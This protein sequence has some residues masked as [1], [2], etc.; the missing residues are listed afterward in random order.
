IKQSQQDLPLSFSPNSVES[1]YQK[2]GESHVHI[3]K[4]EYVP[5]FSAQDAVRTGTTTAS[6]RNKETRTNT[7]TSS[8]DG[9]LSQNLIISESSTFEELT[10]IIS[11]NSSTTKRKEIKTEMPTVNALTKRFEASSQQEKIL[12][13]QPRNIS[14]N[15][16]NV[17]E[18]AKSRSRIVVIDKSDK[19]LKSMYNNAAVVHSPGGI[20]TTTIVDIE[21]A[22]YGRRTDEYKIK[23]EYTT[24]NCYRSESPWYNKE[25]Q[26]VFQK[27][28]QKSNDAQYRDRKKYH[29]NIYDERTDAVFQRSYSAAENRNDFES[30]V[31]TS[32][33]DV[34][35]NVIERWETKVGG[36]RAQVT[37][38]PLRSVSRVDMNDNVSQ[39]AQE[40]IVV[41]QKSESQP[42]ERRV[43]I[44]PLPLPIE[45][46][47]EA[48]IETIEV[49]TSATSEIVTD[50][51]TETVVSP[52][53]VPTPSPTID[54]VDNNLETEHLST[55]EQTIT[56]SS[57]ITTNTLKQEKSYDSLIH[58]APTDV[59]P[60]NDY[61]IEKNTLDF[62]TQKTIE[63]LNTNTESISNEK[64]EQNLL[65]ILD[66][67]YHSKTYEEW[68]STRKSRNRSQSPERPFTSYSSYS[69]RS[70]SIDRKYEK[71]LSGNQFSRTYSE[72]RGFASGA[73]TSGFGGGLVSGIS[74]AGAICTTQIR[75]ARER[76]KREIGLLNDRL[77]DYIEKVRFLEAQNQCLSHDIDIL[78]RGF[79]GGGHVS[80]LFDTEIAQAKRILEQTIAGRATFDRDINALSADIEAI[81][82][83]W[84]ETVTAVKAHR[85]DHDVDLDRLAKIEAEISLFKRK[86]RIVE[87]DVIRIRR[88]NDG[89]YNEIARIKQ[90]T[91]NEVALRNERSLNVQD[92]L[93]RIKLLQTENNSRIE[94]ELVFIR[95]DTTAE[96][97]DYFRHELQAAIRDIRADYE[98]SESTRVNPDLYKEELSS[99]RTTVTNVKSR[100]AEVEGRVSIP[101][102]GKKSIII[103][104]FFLEKLI[105]DLKNNEESK[106]YEISLSEKDAQ[107][108]RLREQCT[109]L[110]IQMEKLCDNEISLRAEIER[111]RILLNGANVT[112]YLPNTH[113]SASTIQVGGNIG[114]TR[115]ISE[116]TRTHS[117]SNTS[118]S[119][120]PAHR[121][122][123]TVGGNIGGVSVGGTVG[124]N[125][126][127]AGSALSHTGS[128]ASL[129]SDKRPDRV[130]DEKGNDESGRSYHRWYLGTISINQ[131]TPSY[132][133]LKNICKIRRVDVGGF[134]VEQTRNGQLLGS[135]QINVPLILDPQ[136]VVRF[137][138]RH[139][140][141]LGQF[142]MDVDAFDNSIEARTSMFNYTEPDVE[143]AWFVY[144]D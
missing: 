106:L 14:N 12:P 60:F 4:L 112:T 86:I 65:N 123:Y 107:I 52:P 35:K 141:Y 95:R 31:D 127:A 70:K 85:E 113:P 89:I 78:R 109:E 33:I 80:G 6:N 61:D 77:A 53:I 105:E 99:I 44:S 110:S 90:L 124:V 30:P 19:T 23:E 45:K 48:K 29:Q 13:L 17:N 76:E 87:E 104:N 58:E 108:A 84:I 43:V 74:S 67:E 114:T 128:V 69:D 10:T 42:I 71:S 54:I 68:S 37:E 73:Y 11:S 41:I 137:N 94:Q 132:I 25:D 140:K 119:G 7:P 62:G 135:A 88:E 126:G 122:G 47:E 22:R 56:E 93:Q 129:I 100:L 3:R 125:R 63:N 81:R 8:L 36:N 28:H 117:S 49:K 46:K 1:G 15:S 139:G 133:E 21:P 55:I 97:R 26:Q 98:V 91:N 120:I 134:R 51:S 66:R 2:S 111:Y 143:R 72:G 27:Q 38:L 102:E 34:V 32:S 24:V 130:H 138:N 64:T 79:S 9:R 96:N 101:F 121:T 59:K 20:L 92:L 82:K 40:K 39:I 116:T 115:V 18:A 131:V 16:K 103:Q 118:Y 50:A 5:Y 136:E 75:D 142:F 57:V 83:K 144:L